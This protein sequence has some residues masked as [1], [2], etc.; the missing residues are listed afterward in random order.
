MIR[1]WA[2]LL[3]TVVLLA[4]CGVRSAYNNLDWLMMRWVNGQVSLDADQELAVRTALDDTLFWHCQTELP[5]YADFLRSI[6]D[7]VANQRLDAD[8]FLAHGEQLA[9][10]GRR[11]MEQARPDLIELM[12]S[13]DDDQ[14]EELRQ[15]FEERNEEIREE[16]IDVSEAERQSNQVRGMERGMRRFGGRITEEQRERLEQWAAA[17]EPS[18]DASMAQRQRWQARFFEALAVRDDRAEFE[19]RM[20]PLLEPGA[21]WSD[22]YRSLME[23]NRLITVEALAD[24]HALAP[25]RQLRRLQSR[26][27]GWA[28]DFDGLTCS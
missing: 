23:T 9:V 3:L 25:P 11:L 15:G 8:R 5:L 6:E 1:F 4:G 14:I 24:V 2:L 18:A 27:S 10:F 22:D 17:L 26:L 7:D 13:L 28:D 21:H 19:T 16:S 12:A 20:T